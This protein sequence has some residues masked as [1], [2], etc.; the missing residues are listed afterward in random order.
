MNIKRLKSFLF[1]V[2]L[3]IFMVSEAKAPYTLSDLYSKPLIPTKGMRAMTWL[4]DGERYSCFE[5]NKITGG[6]DVVAYRAKDNKREVLIP[7][8][9]LTNPRTKKPLM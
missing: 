1:L 9:A 3:C 6:M 2:F 5:Q 7:S 8:S 4:K